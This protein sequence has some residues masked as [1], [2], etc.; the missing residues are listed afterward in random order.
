MSSNKY[1][2]SPL[3]YT[4]TISAHRGVEVVFDF[5]Q[6]IKTINDGVNKEQH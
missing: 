4:G 3:A 5:Q 2:L 1:Y 6:Q